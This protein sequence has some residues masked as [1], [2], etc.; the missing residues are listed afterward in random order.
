MVAASRRQQQATPF[1]RTSPARRAASEPVDVDH[2]HAVAE[3]ALRAM[4]DRALPADPRTY[5][6]W[7]AAL[8]EGR[9]TLRREID[10]A[11]AAHPHDPD[12]ALATIRSVR[13]DVGDGVDAIDATGADMARAIDATTSLIGRAITVASSYGESLS[14]VS[15]ELAPDIA[16][17]DLARTVAALASAT[18]EAIAVNAQ[19]EDR[20][21]ETREEV[22]ALRDT[23]ELVRRDALS[24]AL[25]D[26]A[27]RKRFDAALDA[28]I[29]AASV[30]GSPFALALIDIDR[31]KQFNDVHGHL[32]GDQVL[33]LVAG[34]IRDSAPAGA[35][36]ARFGGEEF[37]LIIPGASLAEGWEAAETARR[38]AES[39]ELIRRANGEALG[40]VTVSAGVA[41]WRQ[42]DTAESLIER[43]DRGLLTAKRLGR[44][45]V[46]D[47]TAIDASAA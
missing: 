18:R 28:V 15:V 41:C 43:A 19:L 40:R 6:L 10:Q 45:R 34:A 1:T 37:A 13:A 26:L 8:T 2:S 44:N 29:E 23:L 38:A 35:L 7:F 21:R 3:K 47:E 39:R 46:V 30:G 17:E 4:R 16:R 22:C 36:A 11:L 33:R 9:R 42:D 25:T 20:L 32:I 14:G 31:F 12:L 5:A 24:D 27:N